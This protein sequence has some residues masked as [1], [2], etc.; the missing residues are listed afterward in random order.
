MVMS[1]IAVLSLLIWL[2]LFFGH[3]KFWK[4]RRNC[5]LL[6]RRSFRMWTSLFRRAMKRKR[7]APRLLRCSRKTRPGSIASFS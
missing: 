2:Y 4:S 5:R 1:S 7:S 3:G 6:P